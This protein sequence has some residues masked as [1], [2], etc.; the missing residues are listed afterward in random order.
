[1]IGTIEKYWTIPRRNIKTHKRKRIVVK[2]FFLTRVLYQNFVYWTTI[3]FLSTLLYSP[4][5]HIISRLLVSTLL[6]SLS[7]EWPISKYWVAMKKCRLS[8]KKYVW[9]NQ[10]LLKFRSSKLKY[11]FYWNSLLLY[12]KL[13]TCYSAVNTNNVFVE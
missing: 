10:T 6:L 7:F 5:F 1:M 9:M 13:N 4:H 12:F 3:R 2:N 11:S 8:V